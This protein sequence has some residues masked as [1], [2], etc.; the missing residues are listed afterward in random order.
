MVA[1]RIHQTLILLFLVLL[2][3]SGCDVE[4]V[5]Q[6]GAGDS[7]SVEASEASESNLTPEQ[8]TV[9]TLN[10][11]ENQLQSLAS[12][13]KSIA[14]FFATDR[15]SIPDCVEAKIESHAPASANLAELLASAKK[16]SGDLPATSIEW[17][18]E[19]S[20]SYST[21]DKLYSPLI[22]DLPLE[23]VQIGAVAG[24]FLSE[25][26]FAMKTKLEGRM[27]D[28]QGSVF[29]VKGEQDL[30]W[31]NS[32]GWKLHKWL[33]KRLTV[34]ATSKT[35]F[36]DVTTEAVPDKETRERLQRSSHQELIRDKAQHP[37]QNGEINVARPEFK[38]FSDW[39]S[40]FQYPSVSVLDIDSDGFDDL[41]V[42]DRWQPAQMLRNRGDGTFEDWTEKSGLAIDELAN[43]VYFAD[44]DN[45]GD[46]DAFVG[47]SLGPSR[48]FKNVDGKFEP[49]VENSDIL[50]ESKFVT[51]ASVVDINRDGLLDLYLSTYAFGE[52]PI[53]NWSSMTAPDRD[54]LKTQMRI[55]KQHKYIDRGGPPNIVL[56]NRGGKF[57]WSRIDDVTKQFRD[58]YQT[59]WTD[60]DGD[61]DLDVYV[62]NDFAYDAVLKNETEQGSFKPKFVDATDE[63]IPERLMNFSM[64]ASIGDFDN[65]ADLD[66]YVSNMYSKAGTRICAQI[67]S[68][69]ERIKVSARGNFLYENTD[70]KLK[71]VAGVTSRDQHVAKVGWSYGGQFADFDN[72]GRLDIYVPS[73]FYSPPSEIHTDKDL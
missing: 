24:K 29:G 41:Y 14:K 54:Q 57:E 1:R 39:Y 44:F 26:L 59:S 50:K 49:D 2:V 31:R 33:Q 19:N 6:K 30:I 4:N 35:L 71:Q 13:M 9:K 8:L 36:K 3:V 25:D 20:K 16:K 55:Q 53:L 22:G 73:G 42:T 61:G 37:D 45:D 46:P 21:L 69:D 63:F 10:D 56:M 15:S 28:E 40:V 34:T 51:S 65:D 70:G 17:P 58:S 47:I 72:D 60:L 32:D 68:V 12:E 27:V 62:C 52:G 11:S 43:C 38:A 66:L 64:G 67:D 5:S 23:E 18:C 7:S 48:F